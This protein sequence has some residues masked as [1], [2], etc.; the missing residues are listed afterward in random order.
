MKIKL[1]S[2]GN[3]LMVTIP[4][5]ICKK[6]KLKTGDILEVESRGKEIIMIKNK[7]AGKKLF[8]KSFKPISITPN[9]E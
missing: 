1:Q 4:S 2:I 8:S 3:S 7:E 5:A 9:N 6:L